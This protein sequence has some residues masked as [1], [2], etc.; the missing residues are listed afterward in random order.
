ML[1]SSNEELGNISVM[2]INDIVNESTPG[3]GLLGALK[4]KVGIALDK[5]KEQKTQRAIVKQNKQKWYDNVKKLQRMGKNMRDEDVY[6]KEMHSYLSSNNQVKLSKEL[7][8]KL[9]TA[10]LDDRAVTDIMAQALL[11]RTK[12]QT[13]IPK[14]T[15]NYVVG[16]I[17]NYTN[18]KGETRSAE[19]S[20]LLSPTKIQLKIGNTKFAIDKEQIV[21]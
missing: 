15:P 19:V 3:A 5:H 1:K 21:K 16:D 8:Q 11:D 12:K 20:Q 17:V 6:R 2:K 10:K 14:E 18:K 7:E 13:N 9:G 4:G